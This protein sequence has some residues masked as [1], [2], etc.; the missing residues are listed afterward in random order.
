M[1][2]S[3]RSSDYLYSATHNS[4]SSHKNINANGDFLWEVKGFYD[5]Q[6]PGS[7]LVQYG[8]G[9]L[10]NRKRNNSVIYASYLSIR[11]G[12]PHFPSEKVSQYLQAN[13]INRLF[14]GHQPNGDA[15]WIMNSHDIQIIS[16]DSA[17]SKGVLWPIEHFLSY[18]SSY[19]LP[20]SD[21]KLP[22]FISFHDFTR[23]FPD[24][25]LS[26]AHQEA[27]SSTDSLTT[28]PFKSSNYGSKHSTRSIN[29]MARVTLSF[30][31][32]IETGKTSQVH[33][34]GSLSDRSH[35][36]F[37]LKSISSTN[38]SSFIGMKVSC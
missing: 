3:H 7:R 33:F 31:Q 34:N 26:V 24:H 22:E 36:H 29:A 12:K 32:G 16:A 8:M 21:Q 27:L 13:G 35:Y 11:D 2:Y 19:V 28:P 37:D 1:D 38:S 14:V 10:P 9:G 5:H 23:K 4:L 6:Q 20:S 17:Y 15:P 30:P 18:D 25:P